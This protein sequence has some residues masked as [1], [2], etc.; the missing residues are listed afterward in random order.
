MSID[1]DVEE[2]RRAATIYVLGA[3]QRDKSLWSRVLSDD[4]VIEGTG[5]PSVPMMMRHV[6]PGNLHLRA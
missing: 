1:R 3:D 5:F 4:C 6:P 2:L